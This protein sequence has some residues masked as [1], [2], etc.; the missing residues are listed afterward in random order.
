MANTDAHFHPKSEK[1]LKTLQKL[2]LSY[3]QSKQFE[4]IKQVN[5]NSR[6]QDGV[7]QM[8]REL[9]IPVPKYDSIDSVNPKN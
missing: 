7:K 5:E 4:K 9:S 8:K 2:Y 3:E 6:R 1:R